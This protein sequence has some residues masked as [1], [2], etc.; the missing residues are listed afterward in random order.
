MRLPAE[1]ALPD[2]AA[3][4]RL[5]AALAVSVAVYVAIAVDHLVTTWVAPEVGVGLSLQP[6]Y[7]QRIE[8]RVTIPFPPLAAGA[9]ILALAE[10]WRLAIRLQEEAEATV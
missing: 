7:Q 3:T 10:V 1:I 2:E 9:L 6:G 4:S 8:P 5:G